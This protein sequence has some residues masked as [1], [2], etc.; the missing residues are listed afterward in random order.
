MTLA[1]L[2][3]TPADPQFPLRWGRVGEIP[4]NGIPP[5]AL[6]LFY[7]LILSNLLL[8]LGDLLW[9][10]RQN[11]RGWPSESHCAFWL[12]HLPVSSARFAPR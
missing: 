9:K 4:L 11:L 12:I 6:K 1:G 8:M 3:L 2:S 5:I 10:A 7:D